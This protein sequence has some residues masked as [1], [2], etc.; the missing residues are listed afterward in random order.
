ME[1]LMNKVTSL[2]VMVGVFCLLLGG[3]AQT[4]IADDLDDAF[5]ADMCRDVLSHGPFQHAHYRQNNY[6]LQIIYSRFLSATYEQSKND[7]SLGF[8]VPV[9]EI[10][11]GGNYDES[12]FNQKKESIRK[13]N[14]NVI[15]SSQEIDVALSSGDPKI[16]DAW[17]TCIKEVNKGGISLKF[18]PIS[19][20]EVIATVEWFAVAG[21][22][23]T[24]LD[25]TIPLP[26]GAKFKQGA[27]CFKRGT[28]LVN[29][30]PCKAVIIMPDAFTTMLAVVSTPNGDFDAY[31]PARIKLQRFTQPRHS[32]L[33]ESAYRQFKQPNG[34]IELTQR[35]IDDGW[36]FDQG[37]A[38]TSLTIEYYKY[39]TNYCR[40]ERKDG[41]LYHFTYGFN[42]EGQTRG[43]GRNSSIGC[44]MDASI[45]M[46]RDLWVSI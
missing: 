5:D 11:L 18:K 7:K 43:K 21:L 8:G 14:L 22:N 39:W 33:R 27:R 20:T 36:T 41:D 44:R 25:E 3:F 12:Q 2:R 45:N 16:V 42:I 34:K 1:D 17:T 29:T 26:K 40:A 4:V 46:I 24:R 28:R 9:G 38:K 32:V 13:T 31:L 35:E 15:E 6:F 30:A 23:Q 10:V 37:S 19:A